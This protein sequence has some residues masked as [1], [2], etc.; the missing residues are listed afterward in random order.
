MAALTGPFGR[1]GALV[2]VLAV[3]ALPW[4]AVKYVPVAGVLVALAL[5]HLW[6]EDRRRQAGVLT[7]GLAFA[8]LAFAVFHRVVYGGWTVYA[9]G[10]HFSETGEVSVI[11]VDPNYVG[12]SQRLLGLLVD[13]SFGLVAWAPVFLF[14]VVAVG[15]LARRR[16]AGRRCCSLPSVVGPRP[17]GWP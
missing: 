3:V 14:A 15:A 8:G 6:R 10:D 5:L 9:S 12:R 13:R 1:R 17:P 16:R 7:G 11:G 2:F 4:L